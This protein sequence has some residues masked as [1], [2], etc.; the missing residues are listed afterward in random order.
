MCYNGIYSM[1][2]IGRRRLPTRHRD[3]LAL[4]GKRRGESQK[5][6]YCGELLLSLAPLIDKT[7]YLKVVPV[8]GQYTSRQIQAG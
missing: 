4:L 8:A 1:I 5:G 6:E 3:Y 2:N 7:K